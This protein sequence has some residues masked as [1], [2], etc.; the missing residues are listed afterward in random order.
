MREVLY[1]ILMKLV[2]LIKMCEKKM[3]ERSV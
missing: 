3:V 1:S 2:R